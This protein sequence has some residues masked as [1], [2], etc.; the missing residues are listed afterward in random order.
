ML[1]EVFPCLLSW[2]S[3]R[4]FRR[5]TIRLGHVALNLEH[6]RHTKK[7]SDKKMAA[8]GRN[9]KPIL[10]SFF[11]SSA[12][13]RVRI[14]LAMKGIDYDYRE[15]HLRKDGGQQ[16]TEE[17]RKLNP[18]EQVPT[19]IIDGHTLFQS[20]PICEYLEET[21]PEVPLLPKDP[22]VRAKARALAEI[23]NSGIQPLQ[24]VNVRNKVGEEKA[25]E[26]VKYWIE[27]GF[28]ALEK[29][30][31][32]TAGKYCIGDKVTLPDLFLV[33]Q[34]YHAQRVDLDMSQFPTIKRI[35]AALSEIDAF[36]TAHAIRQPDTP[37]DERPSSKT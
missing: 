6:Y 37:P 28:T 17:Y 4:R 10:Y 1:K 24:N 12:A 2:P 9:V 29:A 35:D 26:W 36:K 14:A 33:P 32:E 23:I 18:M 15:V 5:A 13:W 19:L 20:L 16:R 8:E 21:R 3:Y 7:R 34:I 27:R 11:R 30:L 31:Q 22:A 25:H